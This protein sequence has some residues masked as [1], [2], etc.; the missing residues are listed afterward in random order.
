MQKVGE[1]VGGAGLPTPWAVFEHYSY[2][3]FVLT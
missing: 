1:K 2:S 3:C